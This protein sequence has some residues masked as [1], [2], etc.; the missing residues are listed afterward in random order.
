VG[1]TRETFTYIAPTPEAEALFGGYSARWPL[2]LDQSQVMV[3]A[4]AGPPC[5]ARWCCLHPAQ[6]SQALCRDPQYPPGIATGYPALVVNRYGEGQAIYCTMALEGADVHREVFANLVRQ[7]AAPFSVRSD[8]PKSVEVTTYHQPD[9]K[10]YI[11]SLVNFQ[12]ELPNI[13]VSGIRVGVRLGTRT[14]RQLLLLPD[15]KPWPFET[16]EDT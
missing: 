5:W 1:E 9:K 14:A 15:A 16:T 2:G 3:Q 11:L 7:M 6:R 13:P 4:H 8:A 12:K 10:R